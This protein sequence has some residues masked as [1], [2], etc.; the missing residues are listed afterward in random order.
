VIEYYAD[1]KAVHVG[2]VVCSGSLFALRGGLALLGSTLPR[3]IALR[4]LSYAIDIVLLSAAI[5]LSGMSRQYPL[6]DGWLTMKLVL[7]GLYI[8]LGWQVLH[9]DINRQQRAFFYLSALT[10][11]LFIASVAHSRHPLG[12]LVF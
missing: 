8:A 7:L 1:F 6:T 10:V 4:R 11:Y 2:A 12:L 3:H 9:A 5:A